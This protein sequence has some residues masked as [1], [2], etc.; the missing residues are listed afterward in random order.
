MQQQ[1]LLVSKGQIFTDVAQARSKKWRLSKTS[2]GDP[3][4]F[5]SPNNEGMETTWCINVSFS[6]HV[7]NI[8]RPL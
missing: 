1:G 5:N 2:Q 7:S 6:W 8:L 3:F 4:S